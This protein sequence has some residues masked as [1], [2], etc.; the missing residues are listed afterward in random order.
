[1]N[2]AS[3]PIVIARVQG[4]STPVQAFDL[5]TIPPA[6]IKREAAS[7]RTKIWEFD[8]NLH[9]SIVGTC[10]STADLR[11][12]LRKAGVPVAGCSDHELH[13]VAVGLAA[14]QDDA[15][16][17]LHKALDHR[18]KLT[19]S[20]FA[21][22]DTEAAVLAM[23]RGAVRRGEIPSAFWATLTHPLTSQA[24][25]REAFGDVHMLSH[26][27]GSANRADLKRLCALENEKAALEA[28]IERQ[29]V[30]LH[31]AIVTRDRQIE[32]LRQALA[33][34]IVTQACDSRAPDETA[35]FGLIA[36]RERRL[37]AET[38]RRAAAEERLALTVKDRDAER[39]RRIAAE[40]A[41]DALREERAAT[42]AAAEPDVA[43]SMRLDGV[44][45]LY[46]GGRAGQIAHIRATV[47]S[48]GA[49]LLH[50][51][52]GIENHQMLLAG[53]TSRCDVAVFPVDCVSHDAARNIKALCRKA[54]KRYLPLRSVGVASLLAALRSW[55]SPAMADPG[56]IHW[57]PEA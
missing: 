50:H 1:M 3:P 21:K 30:A 5:R 2:A 43:G 14:R 25:I 34:R 51:D 52:G 6:L 8:A 39:S 10:L 11:Q 38:R 48:L 9:C 53:L 7:R 27:V 36:D 45:I 55:E 37:A 28:K 35:L 46:V 57:I 15:G 22:A 24:V 26:M 32:A 44:S 41:C 33:E 23:W 17:M 49:T 54:D 13:K 16:R 40:S 4:P 42:E 12:I 47:E 19:V 29:Q 20:Q 18:H 56:A 31:E